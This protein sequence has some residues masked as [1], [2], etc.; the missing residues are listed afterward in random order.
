[1]IG[2]VD[3]GMGNLRSVQRGFE[4]TG[5]EAHIIDTPRQIERCSKLI[6]PGVGAFADAVHTLRN[7]GLI[8]PILDFIDSGRPFLGICLGLQI[9]FEVSYEDGEHTGLGVFRGKVVRFQFDRQA[10]QHR[11]KIPHMGW[12]QITWQRPVPILQ[13]LEQGCYVYFV[14]SYHVVP[15]DDP[16]VATRTDYGYPFVS[17]VWRD[18][19]FA[20]QFHPEKSQKVGLKILENFARL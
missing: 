4:R 18:N 19:V 16:V 8:R 9:L 14:H 3:Y 1:M 10:G 12:N 11:L 7:R 2:I 17:S 15:V 20:T 5:V 13:G 6:V